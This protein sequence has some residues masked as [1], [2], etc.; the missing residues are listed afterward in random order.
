MNPWLHLLC[1]GRTMQTVRESVSTVSLASGCIWSS[2]HS[3]GQGRGGEGNV[4][5]ICP[6]PPSRQAALPSQL[7]CQRTGKLLSTSAPSGRA[8]D[9]TSAGPGNLQSPFGYLC[10]LWLLICFLGLTNPPTLLA[11]IHQ[12]CCCP[13][14]KS[15]SHPKITL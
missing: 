10:L 2:G 7:S 8:T 6:H 4:V 14:Q 12:E 1:K 9:P 13:S 3:S 15:L 5:S 11:G